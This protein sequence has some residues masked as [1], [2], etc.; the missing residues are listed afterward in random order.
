M[1]RFRKRSPSHDILVHSPLPD[2]P[3]K[4]RIGMGEKMFKSLAEMVEN[5]IP[6]IPDPVLYAT[7]AAALQP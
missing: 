3:A 6:G 7:P 1:A 5:L 2:Q 4:M